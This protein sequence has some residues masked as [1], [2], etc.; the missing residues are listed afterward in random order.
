MREAGF[1][2]KGTRCETVCTPR[3]IVQQNKSHTTPRSEREEQRHAKHPDAGQPRTL[4][5]LVGALLGL[6]GH[7]RL[8]AAL[9]GA[10]ALL[11]AHLLL[12]VALCGSQH[13][14]RTDAKLKRQGPRQR[15]WRGSQRTVNPDQPAR[16]AQER[17]HARGRFHRINVSVRPKQPH[18]ARKQAN[19]WTF[20]LEFVL[21]DAPVVAQRR[22]QHRVLC[23]SSQHKSITRKQGVDE[24]GTGWRGLPGAW[25]NRISSRRWMEGAEGT[26]T[27]ARQGIETEGTTR[28]TDGTAHGPCRLDRDRPECTADAACWCRDKQKQAGIRNQSQNGTDQLKA[29]CDQTGGPVEGS[30]T[31][32]GTL[33]GL[34]RLQA[35]SRR[36][37]HH[38]EQSKRNGER[39]SQTRRH[40]DGLT[41]CGA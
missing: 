31:R 20:G 30:R 4:G 18:T 36:F 37:E 23:V 2:A 32:T 25:L 3:S 35:A 41:R 39:R 26:A 10:L 22:V 24:D 14:E 15:D 29:A 19:F 40:S 38:L 8:L 33:A 11:G 9:L 12:V 5:L 34:Q 6:L 1:R 21:V 13:R 7:F 17:A 27:H 16:A 28:H